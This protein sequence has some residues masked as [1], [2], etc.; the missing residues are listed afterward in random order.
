[1]CA[2]AHQ[3]LADSIHRFPEFESLSLRQYFIAS[4]RIGT[5]LR[6]RGVPAQIR[7]LENETS[8]VRQL[9]GTKLDARSAVPLASEGR[10]AVPSPCLRR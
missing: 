6:A 4:I 10:G 7:T 8:C 2:Y 3:Q 1:M 9:C 5:S